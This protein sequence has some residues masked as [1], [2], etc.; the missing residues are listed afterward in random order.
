MITSTITLR[1]LADKANFLLG[2]AVSIRP[3][4]NDKAYYETIAR[5]C[6]IIVAE[7]AFKQSEIWTAPYEY[8]FTDTDKLVAYA[9]EKN[10]QLRGHTLVWHG[11]CPRWLYEGSFTRDEMAAM[12]EIYIKTVV[13]RYSGAID[14]WDVVNEAIDDDTNTHRQ[15]S[16][17]VKTFGPEFI[18]M[19]FHW[20]HEADPDTKL[21]YNDYSIE[22]INPK[23]NAVYDLVAGL[24]QRG[25]PIHG[26]GFQYH[27]ISGDYSTQDFYDNFDRFGKLGLET[28]VTEAD[29]R[30]KNEDYANPEEALK[31]Q[32]AHYKE[33]ISLCRESLNCRGALIW[34]ITDKY[35]W[36][37]GFFKGTDNALIFDREYNPKPAYYAISDALLR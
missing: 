3:F 36:V 7:N 28:M 31:T 29:I 13:G 16:I 4:E 20:A 19:A 12:L 26:V 32:A 33:M 27:M 8:D 25:V 5:E 21:Y 34:G 17:W 2:A 9:G 30:I 10:L 14:S 23:S 11:M 24:L 15:K 22:A 6:N 18:D 37:P 1:E 35:S